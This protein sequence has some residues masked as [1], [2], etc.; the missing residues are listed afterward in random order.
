MGGRGE[1]PRAQAPAVVHK[2]DHVF[3]YHTGKEIGVMQALRDADPDPERDDDRFVVVDVKPGAN[4]T[5]SS[6]FLQ[7]PP[8]RDRCNDYRRKSQAV[9][10]SMV[11]IP[12]VRG[13]FADREEV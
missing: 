8:L 3:Y 2:G 5:L 9:H 10:Q 13:G 11:R 7:D 1:Q 6:G 12:G 4:L